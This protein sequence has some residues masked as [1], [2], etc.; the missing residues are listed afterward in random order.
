[1]KDIDIFI[2][3]L[4]PYCTS[5]MIEEFK[6][7]ADD[8]SINGFIKNT[9]RDDF[10]I[11]EA[12][13][14]EEDDLLYRFDKDEIQ[15]G[16]SLLHF[17]GAFYILDPSSARISYYLAPLL[18][19]NFISLDLCAAPGGKSIALNMRRHDGLY[20]ANDISY[21]RALEMKKNVERLGLCN[22]YTCCIDPIK[23]K[24]VYPDLIIL[25]TPCSGSGMIRKDIKMVEDYSEDKVD[26]LLP[27]QE[28]LLEKA[29]S[30]SKEGTI[31]AYSTCSL[32]IRE[33][34]EQ[35]KKFLSKHKDFHIIDVN[36]KEDIVKGVEGIGYHMIPGISN[37]EGI[38]FAFMI[39]DGN[40]VDNEKRS[41]TEIKYKGNNYISY[42]LEKEFSVLPY[43]SVGLKKYDDSQYKKCP[44]DHSYCKI[45]DDIQLLEIAQ[46]KAISYVSGEEIQVQSDVK[47]G[48]VILTYL[49]N[50]LGLGKKVNNRVKN[51][52]PK[53][54]RE[55]LIKI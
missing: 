6:Q 11:D 55:K 48:I 23:I 20:I 36:V 25:D 53:G 8:K 28:S 18:K 16:K 51:Y 32:S 41:I 31:I 40:T 29:Y 38:Y 26:R 1:M 3:L 12:L 5:S 43:L 47:D 27:I 7:R 15:L 37:G 54:L 33:D 2:R 30:L 4:Q 39:K 34:E 10:T 42:G 50:R 21:Q 46:E 44:F 9:Y 49:G 17:S 24:D 13:K 22:M 35:I 19:K 52:L 14:D 45:A